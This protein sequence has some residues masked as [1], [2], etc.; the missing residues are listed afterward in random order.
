MAVCPGLPRRAPG[1]GHCLS[2]PPRRRTGRC[3]LRRRAFHQTGRL[4][5]KPTRDCSCSRIITV[6]VITHLTSTSERPVT[7][8]PWRP[9]SDAAV[10]FR[11]VGRKPPMAP[12]AITAESVTARLGLTRRRN[13]TV[14]PELR[15][16]RWTRMRNHE[17]IGNRP[18]SDGVTRHLRRVS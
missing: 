10:R 5:E 2:L 18:G 14:R 13:R 8:A 3:P 11:P 1:P 9:Q 12:W 6:L 15:V 4:E 7:S 16:S 17:L